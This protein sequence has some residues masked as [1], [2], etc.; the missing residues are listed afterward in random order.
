METG[1][2]TSMLCSTSIVRA[3]GVM[4]EAFCT[5]EGSIA[6][7]TAFTAT[8]RREMPSIE[9]DGLVSGEGRTEEAAISLFGC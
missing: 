3:L 2:E 4:I 7:A 5:C 1:D 9:A 8:R 6:T